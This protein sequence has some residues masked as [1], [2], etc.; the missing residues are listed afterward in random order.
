MIKDKKLIVLD[1]S[2]DDLNTNKKRRYFD[3]IQ[4]FENVG[5]KKRVKYKLVD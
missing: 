1:S 5:R 3:E 2:S 4:H